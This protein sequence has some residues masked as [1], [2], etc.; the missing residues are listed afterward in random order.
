[1]PNPLR[2]AFLVLALSAWLPFS[3]ASDVRATA[4]APVRL[5]EK[6]HVYE[7]VAGWAKLPADIQFGNTHGCITFDSKGRVYMNTDSERAIM[8][9]EPDGTYVRGF[10]KEFQGGLH[11][12]LYRKEADGEYLYLA[13]HTTR[14]AYKITLEG[15]I[16][17]ELGCPMESGNYKS[18][19]DYHPTST[20]VAPNG[21]IFVGDGYGQSWVH[22][23]DSKGKYIRSF[24]GPGKMNCCHGLFIDTRQNP[25]ALVVADR[26]N[27][28]LQIFDLNGNLQKMIAEGF[29]LPSNFG[30]FGDD[31]AVADLEGRVTIVDKEYKV[32]CHLGDNAEPGLRGQN[33]VPRDKWKDGEFISPHC[34]RWDAE[35][36]LYVM[37][38]NFLGRISKLKRIK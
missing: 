13:H 18:E 36:N 19:G 1:M 12:M 27:H 24:G 7:W 31:M 33:G 35:G 2:S 22:Q 21:D 3:N 37:D 28:R 29:R 26:A 34:A 14:K 20:V 10:G 6:N 11:S 23:Y 17:L 30:I 4:T 15:K 5:G 32:V 25:P 9:F 38:W 8:V 16:V